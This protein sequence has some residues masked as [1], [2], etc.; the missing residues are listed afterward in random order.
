MRISVVIPSYNQGAYLPETFDSLFEQNFPD[1]EVIVIDGASTDNSVEV[2]KEYED[3]LSYWVSEP[4]SGQTDAINKGLQRITGEVWCYLNSDDLLEPG[5]LRT[6]ARFFAGH[7]DRHWLSGG[8][9]IFDENGIIRQ[10]APVN[11]QKAKDYLTPWNRSV[12]AVFPFSGACFLRRTVIE[13]IGP[14]DAAYHYSMDMEY[15]ARAIFEG[16]FKQEITTDILARWRWHAESKTMV[17]GITYA[18]REDELAIAERFKN[19]LP[20]DQQLEIAAELVEQYR[21]LPIRKIFYQH[22]SGQR[23]GAVLSLAL[24]PFSHPV[25]LAMANYYKAVWFCLKL[26]PAQSAE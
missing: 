25:A 2:I 10:I 17:K 20:A 5:S 9:H 8:A 23:W 16:G 19:K 3:Q 15:Y 6:V 1:L 11:T 18:F 4:D 7:P 12:R 26:S 22:R 14:F 21:E 13:K 24:L